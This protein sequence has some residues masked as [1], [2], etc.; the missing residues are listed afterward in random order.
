MQCTLNYQDQAEGKTSAKKKSLSM[1]RFCHPLF[2]DFYFFYSSP[3]R[4][5]QI[6]SC[7]FFY[8]CYSGSVWNKRAHSE[9]NL[10]ATS[11]LVSS[12][13]RMSSGSGRI[14]QNP[15]QIYEMLTRSQMKAFRHHSDYFSCCIVEKFNLNC[16]CK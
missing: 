11:S 5:V 6:Q 14:F 15:R 13:E 3:D 7:I 1:K 9:S 8:F 4:K 16:L 10:L 12:V 2:Q